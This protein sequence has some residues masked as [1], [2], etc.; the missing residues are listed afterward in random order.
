MHID[1]LLPKNQS[2][3]LG[4]QEGRRG[5]IFAISPLAL[6]IVG[7]DLNTR[8]FDLKFLPSD[9]VRLAGM[10]GWEVVK[11]HSTDHFTCL[12]PCMQLALCVCMRVLPVYLLVVTV[13]ENWYKK[14]QKKKR[15][16]PQAG[17]DVWDT[18]L[19]STPPGLVFVAL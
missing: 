15:I 6:T 12:G 8:W 11:W 10:W 18:S 7:Q 4:F 2:M 5:L 13:R 9:E 14:D 3:A 19:P 16:P 1:I 17:C